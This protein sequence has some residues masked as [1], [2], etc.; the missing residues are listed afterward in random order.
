MENPFGCGNASCASRFCR[1]CL[2]KVL[3]QSTS[4]GTSPESIDPPPPNSTRCPNCR[5][6]FSAASVLTDD[7][8]QREIRDCGLTVPCQFRGCGAR[9]RLRDHVAHESTCPHAIMGCRYAD[10]GCRWVGRRMDL[11]NHDANECEFRRGLGV[12]V[13]RLRRHE[14]AARREF[15]QHRARIGASSHMIALH[16]RQMMMARAR[17]PY[18]VFDVLWLAYEVSLF[19]GR[20]AMQGFQREARCVVYNVLLLLPS[21]ALAFN[22]SV[23]NAIQFI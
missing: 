17:N 16:S 23:R 18:N 4:S 19:S 10:W 21:L 5:S 22:V 6:F 11:T 1:Q 13:E 20:S 7:D 14:D 8:L 15:H 9:L 12:L 2:Q 3:R